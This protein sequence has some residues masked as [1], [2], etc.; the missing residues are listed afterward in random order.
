MIIIQLQ[1]SH[2]NQKRSPT[3]KS[4]IINNP[5]KTQHTSN[6]IIQITIPILFPNII[7]IPTNST[8]TLI[9]LTSSTLYITKFITTCNILI[10]SITKSL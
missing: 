9:I 3:K 10:S 7:P 5:N 1:P 4:K 2:S 6:R 8:I